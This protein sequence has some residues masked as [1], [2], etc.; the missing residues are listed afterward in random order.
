MRLF[1]GLILIGCCTIGR[2]Q[3]GPTIA[4]INPSSVLAGSPS[5][6]LTVTGANFNPGIVLLWDTNPA[7]SVSL[8]SNNQLTVIIPAGFVAAPGTASLVLQNTGGARS[9]A[10]VFKIVQSTISIGPATLPAFI[11]GSPYSVT[12]TASGGKPP[13]RWGFAGT[14][15]SG[16]NLNASTGVLSG[17]PDT[18]GTYNFTIGVTDS[19]GENGIR[20]FSVVVTI[21]P[22]VITTDSPIFNGTL[23]LFYS[24]TFQ[25]F[26]GVS[27]YKWDLTGGQLPA[28]LTFEGNSGSI[29]GTPS[30]AGSFSLTIQVTDSDGTKISK[31]FQ[32]TV[33]PPRLSIATPA[34]LPNGVAG[35]TYSQQLTASGGTPPY[36]WSLAG[37][38]AGFALDTATGILTGAPATPGTL[39]FTVQVKDASGA[40]ATK[41]FTLVIAAAPLT[42]T[43]NPKLADGVLG[44]PYAETFTVSGGT[45]PYI[46]SANGL[47]DG[48]RLDSETGQLTGAPLA[49]GDLVFTVRVTDG[50]RA[51]A[52]NLFRMSVA[53]PPLPD[54]TITGLP[55][56]ANPADQPNVGLSIR[57]P[58]PI[59]L[60]GQLTLTFTPDV[61]FG[62]ATI[63]FN[64]GGRIA[65]FTI[66]AGSTEGEFAAPRLAIQ[67]GTLAG[68]ITISSQFAA[69]G[70]DITPNPP[71]ART[72]H[73]NRSAPVINSATLVRNDKGF[74]IVVTGYSTTREVSQAVFRFKAAPGNNLER[75]EVTVQVDSLFGNWYQ[76]STSVR[77]GSQFS[78]TQPFTISGDANAVI[79]DSVTL[80][81]RVGGTTATVR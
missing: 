54:S 47:P 15:P 63:Q 9:N 58:Y 74:N 20:T 17:T 24:Q 50:A 39:S 70:I 62:D 67:T 75:T 13:F 11:V 32:F 5:F 6:T 45:P 7:L 12:F 64:T 71:P 8:V 55:D 10:V 48:L 66:A 46:W 78:F 51:T 37:A 76:D 69:S 1:A 72:I 21:P 53:L 22:L 31:T 65:N 77:Y 23:G 25:A 18:R 41:P 4:T 60:T 34:P 61:G 44:K 38:L 27:P 29:T 73:V 35:S 68:T 81:N 52:V 28:G 42:I 56:I 26:G 30:A 33:D 49:G 14:L 16:L 43:S 36:T 40:T 79:P 80:T 57:E 59:A 3:P 19:T 2:A